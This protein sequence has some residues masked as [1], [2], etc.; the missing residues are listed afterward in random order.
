MKYSNVRAH[1]KHA[2]IVQL[3]QAPAPPSFSPQFY[4]LHSTHEPI[5]PPQQGSGAEGGYPLGSRWK[6]SRNQLESNQDTILQCPSYKFLRKT[7]SFSPN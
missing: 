7:D 2:F 4:Y 1:T 5:H 6:L 3:A